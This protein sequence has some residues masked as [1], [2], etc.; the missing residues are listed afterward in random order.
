MKA[1]LEDN[2]GNVLGILDEVP[3]GEKSVIGRFRIL[4]ESERFPVDRIHRVETAGL[5]IPKADWP[6]HVGADT[7]AEGKLSPAEAREDSLLF[8]P[9]VPPAKA[10]ID[11]LK[12]AGLLVE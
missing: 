3:A 6:A 10:P 8:P 11:D 4:P 1:I 12:A 9:E 5:S 7:K 2:K